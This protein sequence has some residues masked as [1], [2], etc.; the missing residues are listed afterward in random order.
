MAED[1]TKGVTKLIEDRIDNFKFSSKLTN[2]SSKL[3]CFSLA[4]LSSLF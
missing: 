1:V 3:E 2:G 4:S